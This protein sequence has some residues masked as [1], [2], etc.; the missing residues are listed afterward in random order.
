MGTGNQTTERTSRLTRRTRSLVAVLMM[1]PL[2]ALAQSDLIEPSNGGR[3]AMRILA[4]LDPDMD[5]AIRI[6]HIRKPEG[7]AETLLTLMDL[8]NDRLVSL[9]EFQRGGA[10]KRLAWF[11]KADE[12]KDERLSIGEM[13]AA[14]AKPATARAALRALDDD[15]DGKLSY[16]ELRLGFPHALTRSGPRL[17][18]PSRRLDRQVLPPCWVPMA[19]ANSRQHIVVPVS[20]GGCNLH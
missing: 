16:G 20:G 11:R 7:F 1:L 18:P 15:G 9:A 17:I 2:P 12:N 6:D 8:D 4:R 5:R 19:P 10:G 3:Q 13:E 14:M